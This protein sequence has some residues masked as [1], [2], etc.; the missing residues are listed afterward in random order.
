MQPASP[1]QQPVRAHPDRLPLPDGLLEM[2]PGRAQV[3][4]S[5]K[6]E[7]GGQAPEVAGD[8]ARVYTGDKTET[9]L[10]VTA[11]LDEGFYKKSV[12]YSHKDVDQL[13]LVPHDVCPQWNY[14]ISP[15]SSTPGS[16]LTESGCSHCLQPVVE[17]PMKDYMTA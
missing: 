7:P 5:N 15:Q 17:S 14:T 3:V 4:Q 11:Q 2:E 8:H 10:A 1:H 13:G 6:Q 9:G 12:P 16:S